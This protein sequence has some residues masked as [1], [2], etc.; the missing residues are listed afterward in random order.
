MSD[1][2]DQREMLV[3]ATYFNV[4]LRALEPGPARRVLGDLDLTGAEDLQGA[5][6]LGQLQAAVLRL[7]I[8]LGEDWHLQL[9]HRMNMLAHGSLGVAAVTAPDMDAAISVLERYI[10]IRAPFV[11]LERL[12]NEHYCVLRVVDEAGLGE[13]WRDL[14]EIVVLGIQSLLEQVRGSPLRE[15]QIGFAFPSPHYLGVMT[16]QIQ[17]SVFFDAPGHSIS[18]PCPWLEQPNP[19]QERVMHQAALARIEAE[20][21][22]MGSRVSVTCLVE[23]A[24]RAGPEHVPGLAEIA[25]SQHIAPRTLIRK[26]K[27]EGSSYHE[28][29]QRV[30]KTRAIEL[31]SDSSLTVKQVSYLLGYKDPSN[32]GRAFAQWVGQSPGA[33][34]RGVRR[35]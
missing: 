9:M 29:L 6:S 22:A 31:L 11:R 24:L 16:A 15:A 26:L 10:M 30:R 4:I 19:M 27:R 18:L 25:R 1:K 21:E 20:S 5:L 3:P 13:A 23:R 14:L 32:F 12:V 2:S 34:R 28:I 33:Y 35:K 7:R 8:L 17:G